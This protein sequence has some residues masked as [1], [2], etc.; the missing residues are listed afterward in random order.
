MQA[1]PPKPVAAAPPPVETATAPPQQLV[2]TPKIKPKPVVIAPVVTAPPPAVATPV[3]TGGDYVLQ[4][5]AY[6]SEDEANAAWKS[7]QHKHPMLGSYESD[8][9]QVDLADKGTW[10]R[11]RVGAFPTKDAAGAV[12]TKLKADGGDCLLAKK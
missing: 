11:L 9:K 8:V 10:Y 12:C 1:T 6:K 7:Y 5:G 2:A 3:A 4:I